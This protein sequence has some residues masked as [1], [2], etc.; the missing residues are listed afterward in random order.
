MLC[1][2]HCANLTFQSISTRDSIPKQ[3]KGLSKSP[4][5]NTIIT[6]YIQ[7]KVVCC[8]DVLKPPSLPTFRLRFICSWTFRT[9]KDRYL[10]FIYHV[11]FMSTHG[12]LRLFVPRFLEAG[13][14]PELS[15]LHFTLQTGCYTFNW[16]TPV[17][18]SRAFG[19]RRFL[20]FCSA[21][22]PRSYWR[23]LTPLRFLRYRIFCI[24]LPRWVISDSAFYI[25]P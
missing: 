16:C 17:R 5:K 4:T 23:V 15:V 19:L 24:V 6:K 10:S 20:L 18:K 1:E 3:V 8:V 21:V 25:L 2:V 14:F 12:H 9:I 11:I 22:V 13:R 7:N